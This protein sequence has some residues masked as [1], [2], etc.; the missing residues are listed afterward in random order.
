M[1]DDLLQIYRDLSETYNKIDDAVTA[2]Q[3]EELSAE[4]AMSTI[5]AII[6]DHESGEEV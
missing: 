1:S 4:R 6:A 3:A 5:A 2:Y